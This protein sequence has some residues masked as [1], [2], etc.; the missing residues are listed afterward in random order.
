MAGDCETDGGRD[1]ETGVLRSLCGAV[2]ELE[3]AIKATRS[4]MIADH[5]E[6][7]LREVRTA[8]RMAVGGEGD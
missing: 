3:A 7:A 1:T 6:N 8:M 2:D 5:C 4:G